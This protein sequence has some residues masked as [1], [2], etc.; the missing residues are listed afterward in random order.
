MSETA[1]GNATVRRMLV[2]ARLRQLREAKGI[3]REEAGYVIRASESKMSRVEL[4]RVSFKERDIGD[5]LIHYGVTDPEQ[6][7]AMLAL[8]REANRPGWWR[9]YEDVVPGW[10]QNYVGLEEAA[11]GIRSYEIQFVPGLL[12]TPEYA[13]AVI[14]S[15]VPRP[16]ADEVERAVALRRIRQR[17]LTR[18]NPPRVW[19]VLEEAALRRPVGDE[20]VTRGQLRHL[21]DLAQTP[22]VALQI[23]P[24]RYGSHSAAG[25]AFSILRFGDPDLPDVVYVEQLVS[26]LY[27]DKVEHVDRYSEVL[28][29]LSVESLTPAKSLQL[30]T[31]MLAAA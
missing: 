25:G 7:E 27:L 23:L 28:E 18:E 11:V 19:V 5:L 31:Q 8:V 10:F 3:T 16:A 20:E 1:Q 29:R 21:I 15:G 12:Q 17:M 26:A 2:G 14:A 4:G 6:R 30:L 24:L 13:R 9:E 22:H